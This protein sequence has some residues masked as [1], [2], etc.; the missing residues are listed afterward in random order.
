MKLTVTNKF[1]PKAVY[2]QTK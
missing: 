2:V 1:D